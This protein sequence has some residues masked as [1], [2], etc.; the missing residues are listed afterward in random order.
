MDDG[1]NLNLKQFMLNSAPPLSLVNEIGSAL[2]G[3]LARLHEWGN[4]NGAVQEIFDANVEGKHLMANVTYGSLAMMLS[5]NSG[6]PPL[7][8][9]PLRIPEDRL[10]VITKLALERVSAMTSSSKRFTMG[11]FWPGNMAIRVRDNS[12]ERIH[13]LDWEVAK[14]GIPELDV[15]QFC[16]D[17]YCLVKFKPHCKEASLAIIK[18]FLKGYRNIHKVHRS[19]A[20]VI[21]T[22]I[23]AHLIAWPPRGDWDNKEMTREVVQEGVEFMVEGE[24]GLEEWLK[25]SL[26]SPLL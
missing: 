9:P 25:E 2:G 1:G 22:H 16:G 14:T 11:D 26:I 17:V 3:F 12:L 23:G 10:E 8:D 21:M 20:H 18:S 6:M 13:I 5:G 15:G 4:N 7:S 24:A 19:E